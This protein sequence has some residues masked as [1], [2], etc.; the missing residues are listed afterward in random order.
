MELCLRANS[1]HRELEKIS[2]V[3][4]KGERRAPPKAR[5]PSKLSR[6]LRECG[7]K[8][9][10]G[11]RGKPLFAPWRILPLCKASSGESVQAENDL[12]AAFHGAQFEGAK[13][14]GV[15]EGILPE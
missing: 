1:K 11:E 2:V 12:Q 6:R 7:S 4:G 8:E 5:R 14:H 3:S 15:G 10:L 9:R 13:I